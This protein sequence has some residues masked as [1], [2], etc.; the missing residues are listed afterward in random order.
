MKKSIDLYGRYFKKAETNH[1][2]IQKFEELLEAIEIEKLLADDP[3]EKRKHEFRHLSI[4]R[5]LN[6]I[7]QQENTIVEQGHC[8]GMRGIGDGIMRRINEIIETGDLSELKLIKSS[9]KVKALLEIKSVYGLG[10][11]LA[12]NLYKLNGVRTI[13]DLRTMKDLPLPH[14]VITGLRYYDD[15][16]SRIPRD[17]ITETYEIIKEILFKKDPN[18]ISQVCG[19]YRRLSAS[20]S[21]I[22][23]LI[24]DPS[25]I[26][27]KQLILDGNG[28]LSF[29]I[30]KLQ[31]E[32]RIEATLN[33]GHARFQG[34]IRTAHDNIRRIDIFWVSYDSYWTNLLYLTGNDIFNRITRAIAHRKGYTLSNW[35][36]YPLLE[37]AQTVRHTKKNKLDT[38]DKN[39]KVLLTDPHAPSKYITDTKIFFRSEEDIFK[40][41]EIT[42][43][44]P[45]NRQ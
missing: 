4:R 32:N 29:L 14:N 28:L 6:I 38:P 1:L 30:N 8:T 7:K 17:E 37:D 16:N 2:I 11:T 43:I 31:D 3:N 15:I 41:L 26:T 23:I 27:E 19:S 21:D 10:E 45:E 36:L 12:K 44:P 13:N 35:G 25:L 42:W 34:L 18:I 20:S 40:V 39:M 9:D 33:A 24:C 5:G 22:D